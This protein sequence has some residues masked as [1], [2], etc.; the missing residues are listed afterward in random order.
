VATAIDALP[1]GATVVDVG[2]GRNCSFA[3]NL[4]DDRDFRVVAVDISPEEL[5]AN[6]SAD[7][8]RVGDVSE[9][10]PFLDGEVDLVVS[11]T[12]LEHVTSVDR[13]AE[14]MA[15]VLRPGG[16]SIH[17]LPCRY[18]LFAVAARVLPFALAKRVLHTLLPESRGVV[19]FEVFYDRGHPVALERAF[20]GAGF[21][22]VDVQCTWDQSGYF[23]PFFPAFLI[24]LA[25][26]RLAEAL[27][28]RVLAS[29]VVIRATR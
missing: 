20:R 21:A 9:R 5:A 29:Y 27:G 11:R 3:K 24:V 7:E 10:L 12:L 1:S 18:A 13:A 6:T 15:R 28:L 22:K 26:Q 2:G 17:L 23:H 19:E 25:Y 14:E 8:T 4:N 16:R